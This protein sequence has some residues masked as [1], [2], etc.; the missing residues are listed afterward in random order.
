[1]CSGEDL[2]DDPFACHGLL[3]GRITQHERYDLVNC[4]VIGRLSARIALP[5]DGK[6][7]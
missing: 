3:N 4:G 1:M 6:F 5:P 2:L 7:V